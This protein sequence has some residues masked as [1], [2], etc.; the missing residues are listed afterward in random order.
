MGSSRSFR[1]KAS[2]SGKVDPMEKLAIIC[3]IHF[4]DQDPENISCETC[5]DF[6]QGNCP[7]E[8]LHGDECLVCMSK[9]SQASVMGSSDFENGAFYTV[10]TP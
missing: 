5:L 6:K 9:H 10:Q 7:G 8:K 4:G 2:R 3:F 1:R